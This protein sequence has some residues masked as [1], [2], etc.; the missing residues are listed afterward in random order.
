MS[1]LS[2]E[3]R[4]LAGSWREKELY[5]LGCSPLEWHFHFIKLGEGRKGMGFG[6]N[7]TKS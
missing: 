7:T 2:Q 3:N 4:P 6:L 1:C 5:A